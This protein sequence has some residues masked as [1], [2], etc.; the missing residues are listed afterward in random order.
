MSWL[1][2][3]T[4]LRN[5]GLDFFVSFLNKQKGTNIFTIF[6]KQFFRKWQRI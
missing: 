1:R 2:P 4:S 6:A 3:P 5:S